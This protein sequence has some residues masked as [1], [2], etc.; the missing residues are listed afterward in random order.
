MGF[1]PL[2]GAVRQLIIFSAVVYV[3]TLL[4]LAFAPGAGNTLVNLGALRP[5]LIRAGALW[6]FVTY[7]FIYVDPIDFVLSLLGIYFLGWAVEDRVG[8]AKFYL[9]FF[10]SSILS[11][12]AGFGSQ[13]GKRQA[14]TSEVVIG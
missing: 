10:A 6:Q 5:D 11:G 12:L 9:L 2:R 4:L 14:Q 3:V 1:P 13:P 7:P 8:A